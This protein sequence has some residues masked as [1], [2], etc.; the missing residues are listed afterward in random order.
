MKTPIDKDGIQTRVSDAERA[1]LKAA[2]G[3]FLKYKTSPSYD[4]IAIYTDRSKS[5][6]RHTIARLIAK[7][8]LGK[9]TGRVRNLFITELGMKAARRRK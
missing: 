4:E 9:T 3:H 7:G 6:V 2:L 8:L 1:V 5:T